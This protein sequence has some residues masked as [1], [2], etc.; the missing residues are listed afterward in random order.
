MSRRAECFMGWRG[1]PATLAGSGRR[2]ERTLPAGAPAGAPQPLGSG[3][4][5]G[6]PRN[7][8][9]QGLTEYIIFVAR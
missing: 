4:V 7:M 6:W 3:C 8:Y 9:G 2:I 5:V 1:W